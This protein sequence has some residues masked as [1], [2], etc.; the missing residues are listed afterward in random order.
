M[1]GIN[2]LYC[3][4]NIIMC[5]AYLSMMLETG[6]WRLFQHF[7]FFVHLGRYYLPPVLLS[8]EYTGYTEKQLYLSVRKVN[9]D[10]Y[11]QLPVE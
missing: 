4:N 6:L 3:V 8:D 2:Q 9:Y 7:R 11:L 10:D 5:I 1:S